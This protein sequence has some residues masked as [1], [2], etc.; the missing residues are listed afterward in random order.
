MD[1]IAFKRVVVLTSIACGTVLIASSH[2]QLTATT[3]FLSQASNSLS[4]SWNGIFGTTAKSTA[5]ESSHSIGQQCLAL[6]NGRWYPV[7]VVAKKDGSYLIHYTG[8]QCNWDE[9]VSAKRL[10]NSSA[11][12]NQTEQLCTDASCTIHDHST[13]HKYDPN[14]HHP[15]LNEPAQEQVNQ[16]N[17]TNCA[18]AVQYNQAIPHVDPQAS[19]TAISS[20]SSLHGGDKVEVEWRRS[21]Y[22]GTVITPSKDNKCQIHYD[23]YASNMDEWVELK[24]LRNKSN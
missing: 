6:W 2:F 14:S 18:H 17:Q 24:R 3:T 20:F 4:F 23:G 7:E 9:W 19:G 1:G 8:Y 21:W 5:P 11:N 10:N 15:N 13:V 22:A 16:E 12:S